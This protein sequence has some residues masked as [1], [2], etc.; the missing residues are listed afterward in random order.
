MS[1]TEALHYEMLWWERLNRE[2][3]TYSFGKCADIRLVRL[4]FA[5]NA[6][7]V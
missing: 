3:Q 6:D 1:H 5:E 4:A 7:I 2:R